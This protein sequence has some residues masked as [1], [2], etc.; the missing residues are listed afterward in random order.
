[1]LKIPLIDIVLAFS[2]SIDLVCPKLSSH[3]KRVAYIAYCISD[4]MGLNEK[5]KSN[6]LIAGFLHD[7]GAIRDEEKLRAARYDFGYTASE[8]HEHGF[9]GWKLLR[10]VEDLKPAA[11]I[12]KYHH[13]HWDESVSSYPDGE[14]ISLGSYIIHLADR[15]DVL[16]HRDTEILGQR[17][18]IEK[19]IMDGYGKMFMPEAVDAFLKLSSKV[20]FWFDLI[21][22]FGIE[23]I[24]TNLMDFSKLTVNEDK[25]LALAGVLTKIIDF[26]SSFTATHSI[27]VAESARIMAAKMNFPKSDVQL[28]NIAGLLHDLGKLAIPVSILEKNGALTESEFNI[29]KQH[30]YLSY[31]ILERVP[32]MEKINQW[33][34]LHHE[35][36]DGSGY[37][38]GLKGKDLSIGSKIMAISDVFTALTEKRPYRHALS[39]KNAVALMEGMVSKGHL[40]GDVFLAL[41]SHMDEVNELKLT[42]QYNVSTYF[43]RLPMRLSYGS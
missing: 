26:R 5:A 17:S 37:P 23:Q 13:I 1:M 9:V 31:R 15:I 16:I 40:D 6:I 3:N 19:S 30:T 18:Y 28:M 24:V 7:C 33:A 27:G 43:E 20:H 35:R 11:D 22:P 12:I 36:M 38:F 2:N 4:E 39:T 10:D 41:K 25:L 29:M 32:Q 14:N 34:S 21:S 42:A 8:R